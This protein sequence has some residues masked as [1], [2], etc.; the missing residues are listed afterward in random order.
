MASLLLLLSELLRRHEP[1]F[2][3]VTQPPTTTSSMSFTVTKPLRKDGKKHEESEDQ[4]V[5]EDPQEQKVSVE[6]VMALML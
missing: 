1:D 2:A 3:F 5:E 4:S 6:Q